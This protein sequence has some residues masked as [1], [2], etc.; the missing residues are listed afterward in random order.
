M[1]KENSPEKNSLTFALTN[2]YFLLLVGAVTPLLVNLEQGVHF[3]FLE[4]S[5]P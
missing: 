2:P 3:F 1:E 4:I 5:E